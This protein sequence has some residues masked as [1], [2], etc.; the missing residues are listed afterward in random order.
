MTEFILKSVGMGLLVGFVL[1]FLFKKVS[2]IALFL[3]AVVLI[4]LVLLGQNEIINIGWLTLKEQS[5]V[6]TE[7]AGQYR[8]SI[9]LLF[10]NVPFGIGVIVGSFIG[11]RKG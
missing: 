8:D 2:K 11:L 9:S 1:G 10:R 5:N 6:L 3:I 4:G 7:N